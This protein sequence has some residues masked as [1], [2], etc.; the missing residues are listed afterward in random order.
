MEKNKSLFVKRVLYDFIF[1]LVKFGQWEK[2]GF[3]ETIFP[4]F[5]M[6]SNLK[7]SW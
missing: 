7:E 2:D 4:A 3:L 6:Y 1:Y 5:Q